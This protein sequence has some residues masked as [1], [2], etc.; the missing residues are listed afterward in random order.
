MDDFMT[1]EEQD[2]HG[3]G[4]KLSIQLNDDDSA[5][6]QSLNP[7]PSA[8]MLTTFAEDG[9]KKQSSESDQDSGN[10]PLI[11]EST[12]NDAKGVL[13]NSKSIL[14]NG[15]SKSSRGDSS[16]HRQK[17]TRR[18]SGKRK[19]KEEEPE[20][21]EI[22]EDGEIASDGE[23]DFR[24]RRQRRDDDFSEKSASSAEECEMRSDASDNEVETTG[25][26]K[27]ESLS[28]RERRKRKRERREKRRKK[29]EAKKKRRRLEYVDHDKVDD[30]FNWN[31][32][33][34]GRTLPGPYDS[35][36]DKQSSSPY[37][38]PGG[39]Y[40]S[41]Y[42]SPP[43]L[44]D[45]PSE[46]EED[47]Y[48]PS[49]LSMVGDGF[50]DMA[51]A[52]KDEILKLRE[53]KKSRSSRKKSHHHHHSSKKKPLLDI[54]RPHSVC[55]FFMEGK[56]SK[57][58]DCPYSHDFIPPKKS[59]I[60]KFYLNSICTKEGCLFMHGEYPCKYFHTGAQCYQGENCKFS[61]EPL[62][63]ETKIL[64]QKA[65]DN[66][67]DERSD[68]SDDSLTH[69]S[70]E[71]MR[72]KGGN[73]APGSN[74]G[75]K[76]IPSLFDIK[77]YP[78]GQSPKKP[79]GS[80]VQ[81]PGR[82]GFYK[83]ALS[84]SPSGNSS[85]SLPP[86]GAGI[87]GL[88]SVSIR[89]P[90][91]SPGHSSFIGSRQTPG[92]CPPQQQQQQ[93]PP[94]L[95]C[96]PP[97]PQQ[98]AMIGSNY[99]DDKNLPQ[100]LDNLHHPLH[101]PFHHRHGALEDRHNT[102]EEKEERKQ[103]P[104]EIPSH[105]PPKQKELFMR[106]Q[107]Q[108]QLAATI[109]ENTDVRD[110]A[111]LDDIDDWYSS[112][113]DEDGEG[114][115]K[116]AEILKNLNKQPPEP[117]VQPQP[118]ISNSSTLNIMQM[119][120]AIRGQPAVTSAGAG[121]SSQ[122]TVS[123]TSTIVTT[124]NNS[125]SS[126]SNNNSSSVSTST[127]PSSS[128]ATSAAS[129]AGSA[130]SSTSNTSSARRDPRLQITKATTSS[131]DSKSP[132]TAAAPVKTD[133]RLISS[134]PAVTETSPPSSVPVPQDFVVVPSTPPGEIVYR[135][136]EVST[137]KIPL[138]ATI[139][140][141]HSKYKD[142]PR[143]QKHLSN[144]PESLK[145][146]ILPGD[147]D[148]NLIKSFVVPNPNRPG[149]DTT[150][151]DLPMPTLPPVNL[152]PITSTA[153][154]SSTSKR[155][156]DPR[157]T[158]ILPPNSRIVSK[159]VEDKDN[160]EPNKPADP[161]ISRGGP[162]Q[163][164]PTKPLDPRLL[165]LQPGSAGPS[166]PLDP[167]RLK[168]ESSK[169]FPGRASNDPRANKQQSPVAEQNLPPMLAQMPN[170]AVPRPPVDSA[171]EKRGPR[172]QETPAPL[173]PVRPSNPKE[174]QS[175]TEQSDSSGAEVSQPKLDH[176]NDPRFKRKPAG[177]S[178]SSLPPIR[179]VTGQRKVNMEYSSP[180][181]TEADKPEPNSG[182]NSYN[183]PPNANRQMSGNNNNNKMWTGGPD[184]GPPALPSGKPHSSGGN[185]TTHGSLD[186]RDVANHP[187]TSD[188]PSNFPPQMQPSGPLQQYPPVLPPDQPKLKD[189]F[190]IIDPTASP[191]C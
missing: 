73:Q 176:R 150:V 25:N 189:L 164:P 180:L 186:P 134:K 101:H 179:K 172:T 123:T 187:S 157:R 77:V 160:T 64:L 21:G 72:D 181:G 90:I 133:P 8:K 5:S 6:E 171:N 92:D 99:P 136:Y 109:A 188:P 135:L 163:F 129:A 107:Q 65:L 141:F 30:G 54:P 153:A 35:P 40:D 131:S 80:T 139:D 26:E 44:Y 68:D 37:R 82:P 53:R 55:K 140:V 36:S 154:A 10:G 19:Y 46:D 97:H 94:H 151:D 49:L 20:D 59:E 29:N 143:I 16:R 93:T 75:S 165:R 118:D 91:G 110:D 45:S 147:P 112:D 95:G 34:K 156:Q 42:E 58:E 120:N 24:R 81:P 14:N 47:N 38:S 178:G 148:K 85:C 69:E 22:L 43:G 124:S 3:D 27:S 96:S 174:S 155:P 76:K 175:K 89:P 137:Y 117:P 116:L 104:I 169:P 159:K 170:P 161:R 31:L 13:Q 162:D 56:C 184:S 177:E 88:G 51:V 28:R 15:Q 126:S 84:L 149:K 17:E 125:N 62:N 32:S 2:C 4:G 12:E 173:H 168:Q 108:H 121:G 111:K 190:K 158:R 86:S 182:Y 115:P 138:S 100:P 18:R 103:V 87:G 71:H 57:A 83:D 114:G 63:E 183:R 61:H 9:F 122:T 130:A 33:S 78:P 146:K 142:D 41:P 11:P 66:R 167:R 98:S 39:P 105:L 74:G 152:P 52:D 106:I 23:N 60:C 79:Q 70:L 7:L 144:P 145:Q 132:S 128:T 50:I 102:D 191:F 67:D 1:D 113:E 119:I 185:D 127:C 166:R 48:P